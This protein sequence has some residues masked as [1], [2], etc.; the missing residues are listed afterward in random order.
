[1]H[2]HTLPSMALLHYKHVG[3]TIEFRL[4]WLYNAPVTLSHCEGDA[5]TNVGTGWYTTKF[6][7][8]HFSSLA[9]MHNS[10]VMLP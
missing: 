1:M 6:Y 2:G 9:N 8:W 4:R 3:L 7:F 5:T 10:F